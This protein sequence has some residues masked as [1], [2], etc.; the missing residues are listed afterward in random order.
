MI[1]PAKHLALQR[2][3][4]GIGGIIL[5]GLGKPQTVSALWE[6]TSAEMEERFQTRLS[7]GHFVLGLDYLFALGLVELHGGLLVRSETL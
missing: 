2:S 5:R 3:L 7:F 1:L 4:L 6:R